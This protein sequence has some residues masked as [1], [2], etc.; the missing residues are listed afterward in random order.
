MRKKSAIAVV[1]LLAGALM[2]PNHKVLAR[3]GGPGG[4]FGGHIGR[5]QPLVPPPLTPQFNN[6]GP[7]ITL[8]RPGNPVN[9]EGSLPTSPLARSLRCEA[10]IC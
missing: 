5:F 2:L 8:S 3:G 1:A 6:P 4:G 10:G 7:Q 9:Q